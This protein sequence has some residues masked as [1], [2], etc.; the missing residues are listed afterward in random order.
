MCGPVTDLR[1]INED[2]FDTIN[3][4]IFMPTIILNEEKVIFV[5]SGFKNTF[6]YDSDELTEIGVESI[7]NRSTI[8]GYRKLIKD[9]I[10]G[11]SFNEQGEVC[12]NTRHGIPFW[13]EHKSRVVYYK[14]EPYLMSHLLEINDKKKAQSHLSKLLSLRESM[15]E[16]TQSIVRSEGVTQLYNVILKSVIKAIDHARLG[17]VLIRDGDMLRPVAQIGFDPESIQNLKIPL[18]EL[19]LYKAVGKN[20]DRIAKVDDLIEFGEYLRISTLEGDDEFIRSTISAPIY[21]KERFFGVVNVDSTLVNAFDD[22]DLKLMEFVK[23]N[24]EIAISNQLLYEEKAFLS[25]YDSLTSLYNRHYFEEV[26]ELISE[27]ALRYNERFNLVVFDL[28]DLKRTNDE[29]GHIAGDEL[30][31]YFSESCRKLIRKSDILARYGGDE[32]VGIFFNC[33][34]ERLRRRIDGHLKHMRDNPIAI[35]NKSLIC[36]YSYG[37]SVFGDEGKTL[38]ELFKVADDRMYENKIRY[39][40]GFDFIDTFDISK[41]SSIISSNIRR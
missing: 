25:R 3:R 33:S 17:T 9:A 2:D 30:L 23:S 1:Q 18:K 40:L 12:V 13:V 26:F 28:N 15:L 14:D 41:S 36:S 27:R 32:F 8:Q 24:V 31:K 37:I 5:N 11:Q 20:L 38:H 4:L 16:V 7:L 22:D 35:K 10:M 29:N 21:I 6:G 19:F 39:K 34:Q